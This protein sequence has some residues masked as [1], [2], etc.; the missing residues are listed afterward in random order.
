METAIL[1]ILFPRV[2]AELLRL[3]FFDPTRERYVRQLAR[4]GDLALR[5]VQRELALLQEAGLVT[6]RTDNKHVFF[7]AV[8][9]HRPFPALQQLV[10]KI[11]PTTVLRRKA[12]TPRQDWRSS[13]ARRR[14]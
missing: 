14:R 3:L 9:T 6:S 5:T 11:G 10:I 2:R 1:D 12:K 13:R 7:R 8:R 4:G